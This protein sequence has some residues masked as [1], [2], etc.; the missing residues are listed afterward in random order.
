MSVDIVDSGG[1]PVGSPS[2][3]MDSVIVTIGHQSATGIFGAA[4]QKIRLNNDSG[5][6]QWALTL[7]A[8]SGPTAF[9]E[10]T[11]D[12]YDFNDPTASAGDGGD[13]DTL[14]GRMSLNPS[15]GTLG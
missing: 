1:A 8:D 11:P 5:N 3:N 13:T 12:D 6:P 15:V 9:W 7:A 14:G 10:G 4:S 2:V